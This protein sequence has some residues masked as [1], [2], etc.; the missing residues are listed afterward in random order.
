MKRFASF[1]VYYS[2]EKKKGG[3]GLALLTARTG[4]GSRRGENILKETK[5][6]S[7]RPWFW[8]PGHSILEAH[9]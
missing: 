3:L 2:S 9:T 6:C 1:F 5:A 8:D 7:M 4:A